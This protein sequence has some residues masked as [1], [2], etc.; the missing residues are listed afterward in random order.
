MG[1][2]SLVSC[3]MMAGSCMLVLII[4]LLKRR[5]QVVLNFL[6]RMALGIT[7]IIF[8]NQLLEMQGIAVAV[9]INPI[10]LLTT[11]MLGFSGVALLYGILLCSFL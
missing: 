3:G 6:V 10:T 9:G 11:G 7:C 2:A 1:N 5:A 8:V 4:A